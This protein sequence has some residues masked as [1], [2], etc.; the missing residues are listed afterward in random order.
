MITTTEI[1]SFAISMFIEIF[2]AKTR[3]ISVTKSEISL[4]DTKDGI[5]FKSFL[6]DLSDELNTKILFVIKANITAADQEMVFENISPV[7]AP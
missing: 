1:N 7:P 6:K 4:A 5:S 3:N 2:L